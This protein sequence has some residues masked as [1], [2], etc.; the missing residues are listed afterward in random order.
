MCTKFKDFLEAQEQELLQIENNLAALLTEGI[1]IDPV[2][3]TVNFNKN[4]TK[5]VD[6][7]PLIHA[8]KGNGSGIDTNSILMLF[9]DFIKV[10]KKIK[11]KYDTII[12][13][14]SSSSL[15]NDFLYRINK[16]IKTQNEITDL[17][18]KL[19]AS[20]I[21]SDGGISKETPKEIF[22]EL[23]KEILKMIKKDDYFTYKEISKD[24][25]KYI[26]TSAVIDANKI[27]KYTNIIN[28]KDVLILDDTITSGKTISDNVRVLL[29]TFEP[30]S[31]TVPTLFGELT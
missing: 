4:H 31:V 20:D 1:D 6:T 18:R 25:R 21:I 24:Y 2:N 3:K 30:K 27:L 26:D 15:N 5:G 8:L 17:F 10:Q 14:C 11:P 13:V 29:K 7:N 23:Y 12:S 16:V 28:G 19:K 9:R 22:L